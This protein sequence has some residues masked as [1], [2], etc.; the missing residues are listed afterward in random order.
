MIRRRL[1]LAVTLTVALA[2]GLGSWIVVTSLEDR[3]VANVDEQFVSGSLS[4]DIREQLASRTR[5]GPRRPD[6]VDERQRAAI[7]VYGPTGEVVRSVPAGTIADPAPLP[8]GSTLTS[9][10][11][12]PDRRLGRR[13]R[14]PLSGRSPSTPSTA[15]ESSSGLSLADVDADARRGPTHPTPHGHRR[16][17]DRRAGLLAAD[18]AS[19]RADRGHDRVSRTDRGGRP[20]RAHRRWPTSRPRSD[21]SAPP[22]TPCSTGSSPRSTRRPARRSACVGSSPTHPTT[23]AP[24][25]P[26][27]AATPSCTART[28]TTP[29]RWRAA[30]SGS[31]PRRPG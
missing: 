22:S 15:A 12:H 6:V 17:R 5:F 2:I 1:V 9:S 27:C 25:S 24:R 4:A 20:H 7:V 21:D 13:R 28:L 29:S 14:A 26:R 11:G 23:C 30:W 3:L 10:A 18:P 16:H 31:R 8:D 19:V